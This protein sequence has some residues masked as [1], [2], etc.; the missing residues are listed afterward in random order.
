MMQLVDVCNH[1]P[2]IKVLSN[3]FYHCGRTQLEATIPTRGLIGFEFEL[4][5]LTVEE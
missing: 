4:L 2:I 5:N 1:L 3:R